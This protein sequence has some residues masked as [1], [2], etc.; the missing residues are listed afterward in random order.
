MKRTQAVLLTAIFVL[1]SQV[2]RSQEEYAKVMLSGQIALNSISVTTPGSP[3]GYNQN[4]KT[5]G[6]APVA[7]YFIFPNF[8]VGMELLFNYKKTPGE[9]GVA[10]TSLRS[11]S[12][13]PF[14]RYYVING[15]IRPYFQAGAGPGLG[16]STSKLGNFPQSTHRSKIMVYEIKGGIELL[17]NKHFGLDADF[18]YGSTTYSFNE[19]SQWKTTIKGSTGSVALIIYL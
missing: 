18:G 5:I 11:L 8:A 17:V 7:G 4:V 19:G 6:F 15:K 1:I 13:V 14:L 3:G 12:F 16:K 9:D 2:T 10:A